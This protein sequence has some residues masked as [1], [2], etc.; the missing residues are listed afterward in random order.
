MHLNS[1]D[2]QLRPERFDKLFQSPLRRSSD[3]AAIIWGD[4]DGQVTTLPSLREVDLYN[5]QVSSIYTFVTQAA[6]GM[7]VPCSHTDT[8]TATVAQH[9]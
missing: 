7:D 2:V 9:A 5:F 1:L 8:C 4:R 6:G 3:T